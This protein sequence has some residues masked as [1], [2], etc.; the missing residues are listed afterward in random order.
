MNFILFFWKYWQEMI[1]KTICT[2]LSP[3]LIFW[4]LKTAKYCQ[5]ILIILKK[6]ISHKARQVL[7][8]CAKLAAL[9]VY[10]Y[11]FIDG[12]SDIKKIA[13]LQRISKGSLTRMTT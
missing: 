13:I 10:I 3:C 1:E 4:Y 12:H 2:L 11:I 7:W 8:S 6:L 5:T 9:T